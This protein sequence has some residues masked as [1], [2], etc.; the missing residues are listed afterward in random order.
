[1]TK[2]TEK[3]IAY[4]A[5]KLITEFPDGLSTKNLL[6]YLRMK[7]IP[8]GDDTLLLKGRTDDLFS[9]KVRNLKSHNTLVNYGLAKFINGKYFMPE[10]KII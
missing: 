7:M 8:S 6:I 9:Q 2:F 4:C 10:K 5:S 1:M 3:E